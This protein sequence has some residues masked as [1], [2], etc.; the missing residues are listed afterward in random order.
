M[1]AA[2]ISSKSNAQPISEPVGS[3]VYDSGGGVVGGFGAVGAG[4]IVGGQVGQPVG[5]FGGFVGGVG[6]FVGGFGGVGAATWM[7]AAATLLRGS[8]STVADETL[9]A[10]VTG[11]VTVAPIFVRW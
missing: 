9:A 7:T 2:P 5:G 6:G 4:P 10:F 3:P 11:P 1:R 8:G